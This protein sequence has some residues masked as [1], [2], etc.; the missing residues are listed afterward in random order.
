M[1]KD[2]KTIEAR[3][4]SHSELA[5][6]AAKGMRRSRHKEKTGRVICQ[7]LLKMLEC[8]NDGK[9]VR[10]RAGRPEDKAETEQIPLGF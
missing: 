10:K 4:L 7:H 5:M 8:A 1:Y 3:R 2:D 9:P 6:R